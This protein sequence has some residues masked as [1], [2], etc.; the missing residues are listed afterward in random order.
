MKGTSVQRK[1]P[2][3]SVFEAMNSMEPYPTDLPEQPAPAKPALLK[4]VEENPVA[5]V[6]QALA[7]GFAIGMIIRLIEGSQEK[8][9]KINLKRKPSLDE[10]KFHF[11]SLVLPFLWPAWKAAQEGYGKSADSVRD[12]VEQVR[13]GK[14]NKEG[15]AKLAEIEKWAGREAEMLKALGKKGAKELEAWLE[16]EAEQLSDLGEIGKKKA[17][18]VEDWVEKEIIPAAECGW[19]KLKKLL[20]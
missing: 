5:A 12:L 8:D 3:K 7:A 9:P 18:D 15:K 13:K 20:G 14:L 1:C 4:Y 11:G 6:F 10:A 19:K 17:K 16:Q 2:A